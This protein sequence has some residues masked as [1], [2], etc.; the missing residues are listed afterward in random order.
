MVSC[1][2]Y[3]K[4]QKPR[5][6]HLGI[7][8]NHLSNRHECSVN[9]FV[10]ALLALRV[11]A[12]HSNDQMNKTLLPKRKLY[13]VRFLSISRFRRTGVLVAHLL[14]SYDNLIAVSLG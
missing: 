5:L 6:T 11:Q 7:S 13:V 8:D 12:Q 9:G 1:S 2:G 4:Q 3:E 14:E 10:R